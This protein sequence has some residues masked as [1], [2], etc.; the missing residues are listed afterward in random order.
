MYVGDRGEVNLFSTIAASNSASNRGGLVF[1]SGSSKFECENST[2]VSNSASAGGVFYTLDLGTSTTITNSNI[3]RN[4]A[5]KS[6]GGVL[7]VSAFSEA[8]FRNN[9]I[10]YN[11]ANTTGG[12]IYGDEE[13]RISILS[14][15]IDE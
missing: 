2:I 11:S 12:A 5:L 7:F 3:F 10:S 9:N 15:V 6:S 14:S 4:Q 1:L 13:A 8:I